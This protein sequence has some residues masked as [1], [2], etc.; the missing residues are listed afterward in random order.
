MFIYAHAVILYGKQVRKNKIGIREIYINK[1]VV[2]N[3][4][5]FFEL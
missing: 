5:L 2:Y 3:C 4:F 1:I